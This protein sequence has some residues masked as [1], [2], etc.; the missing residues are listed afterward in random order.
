MRPKKFIFT[1]MVILLIFSIPFWPVME[2]DWQD[3]ADCSGA[4]FS[5]GNIKDSVEFSN[6]AMER[7]ENQ[8]EDLKQEDLEEHV[9]R[10]FVN[11]MQSED[12]EV[13]RKAY[14]NN[15]GISD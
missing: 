14:F 11:I 15:C 4:F 5:A 1:W 9:A 7:A 13:T 10:V 12:V 6:R 3:Y 2:P 8:G